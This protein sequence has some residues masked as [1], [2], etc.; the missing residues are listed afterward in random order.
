M[1][2]FRT[3]KGGR[4]AQRKSAC[5]TSK[6]SQVQVLH[7][8]PPQ[9][10]QICPQNPQVSL[11]GNQGVTFGAK[12]V[13]QKWGQTDGQE[14]GDG[15]G[16]VLRQARW[17]EKGQDEGQARRQANNQ[18]KKQGKMTKSSLTPLN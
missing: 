18:G 6:R 3:G 4:L 17:Q 2:Y 5:F 13:G 14:V 1:L 11:W 15:I 8:P 12:F 9:N 16:Q 7:R 10:P